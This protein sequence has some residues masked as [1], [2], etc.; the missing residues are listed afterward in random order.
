MAKLGGTTVYLSDQDEVQMGEREPVKDVARTLSRYL[1][2]VVL[3]TFSQ[4]DMQEFAHYATI[5]IINGLSDKHHPC[6]ALSDLY[7]IYQKYGRLKQL[8]ITYI[9]DGNNVLHS[10]LYGATAVGSNLSIVTPR[11]YEPSEEILREIKQR[12]KETG[13]K[14]VLSNNPFMSL[15]NAHIIYTDVW[16]SM[17]Q[18]RQRE[19]RLRDFQPFQ[20]NQAIVSKALPDA[21]VMHCLPARRDEEITDE[22]LEGPHSIVFDQA[23]NRLHVQK[24]LLLR[25]LTRRPRRG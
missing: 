25:L 9:G 16:V 4:E 11:G 5:P 14:I 6:Q 10:L 23:E 20:V 1:D 13:S 8:N 24:A 7:T 21:L 2:G 17:G 3:R 15:K 22:V 19:Q 12:S 18:E